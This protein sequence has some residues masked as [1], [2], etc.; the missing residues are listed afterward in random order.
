[1]N[2]MNIIIIWNDS[3][4]DLDQVIYHTR[5]NFIKSRKKPFVAKLIEQFW[6][7]RPFA[8]ISYLNAKQ[9]LEQTKYNNKSL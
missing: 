6:G 4:L 5:M 2:Q 7:W 1:M 9:N 8:E 3:V